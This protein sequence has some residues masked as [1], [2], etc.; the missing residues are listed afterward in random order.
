MDGDV[1]D[2]VMDLAACE[3]SHDTDSLP[4]RCV[5]TQQTHTHTHTAHK[6][7][8]TNSLPT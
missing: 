7:K 3:V 5:W 6:A 2:G 8:A 1:H 4:V